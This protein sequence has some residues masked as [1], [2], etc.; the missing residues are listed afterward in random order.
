MAIMVFEFL[1][2]PT[3]WMLVELVGGEMACTALLQVAITFRP[4][5]LAM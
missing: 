3:N 2:E 4:A 1:T 5:E